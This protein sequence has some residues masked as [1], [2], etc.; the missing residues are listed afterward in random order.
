MSNIGEPI[1]AA[2]KHIVSYPPTKSEKYPTIVALHGRGADANDLLPLAESIGRNDMLMI[3]PRAPLPFNLG[4]GFAWYNMGQDW[5]PDPETFSTSLNLLKTFLTQVKAGY[6]VDPAKLILLGFSQGTV[7]TYASGL[8]EPSSVRGIAALSGYIPTRS[9]LPLKLDRL[10][11]LP[12]FIS[13]GTYDDLIP[14]RFGR[15]ASQLLGKAG[16][17]VSFHEYLM[18]HE[19]NGE[20][21]MD[22]ARWFKK[23]L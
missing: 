1:D 5:T 19:V 12:I 17:D 13:H 18:G 4:I 16:A 14:V 15:E 3:A 8:S 9:G 23:I 21:I 7:M 10:H 6:P 11:G 20:T 2:L 22:L